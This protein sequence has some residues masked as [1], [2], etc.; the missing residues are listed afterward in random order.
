MLRIDGWNRIERGDAVGERVHIITLNKC[1]SSIKVLS[2]ILMK[3]LEI[4]LKGGQR[5][6]PSP[7]IFTDGPHYGT[8]AVWRYSLEA[9]Y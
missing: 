6:F 4:F 5:S 1:Q 9:D 8:I 2:L 7:F 3:G